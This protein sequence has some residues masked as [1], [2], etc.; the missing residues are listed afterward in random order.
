[1][2]D[3]RDIFES[4]K[5]FLMAPELFGGEG[6]AKANPV[7]VVLVANG[8]VERKAQLLEIGKDAAIISGPGLEVGQYEILL[9]NGSG[10]ASQS[11]SVSVLS[12]LKNE[13][14]VTFARAISLEVLNYL[15]APSARG[16]PASATPPQTPPPPVN[17][18]APP[19]APPAPVNAGAPLQAPPAPVNA[20]A[21][22]QAPPAPVNAGAPPQAP[23]PPVNAGAPPQAPPASAATEAQLGRGAQLAYTDI[24]EVRQEVRSIQSCRSQIFVSTMVAM[25][26]SVVAVG[27]SMLK[28]NTF[29]WLWVSIGALVAF[30]LLII[31]IT[32][33]LEKDRAINIRRGF[34]SAM[35]SL[36]RNG[37]V[38]LAYRGW[39]HMHQCLLAC[40]VLRQLP[41]AECPYPKGTQSC[42]DRGLNAANPLLRDKRPVPALLDSFTSASTHVYGGWFAAT[43]VIGFE[44]FIRWQE[45]TYPP[46]E[47]WALR[48]AVVAALAMAATRYL[49]V[50]LFQTPLSKLATPLKRFTSKPAIVTV[51]GILG[52]LASAGLFY[53]AQDA[54][55]SQNGFYRTL[56]GGAAVIACAF[57]VGLV[58]FLKNT[59]RAMPDERPLRRW[60]NICLISC[61]L[62]IGV[63]VTLLL[64]N[65]Q[66]VGKA[67]WKVMNTEGGLAG[68]VGVGLGWLGAYFWDNLR[69]LRKGKHATETYHYAWLQITRHCNP[70]PESLDKSGEPTPKVAQ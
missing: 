3:T 38:S 48:I 37:K 29:S 4:R 56:G 46:T 27:A 1:L 70:L 24:D 61:S 17:A 55:A 22:P 33:T 16:T 42:R 9:P 64:N 40:G 34:L 15:A 45:E 57:V 14:K 2:S 7:E 25:G 28:D 44:A 59:F 36:V 31:G 12:L 19:Q 69:E 52:A 23:P 20:G 66:Q 11:C 67:I 60:R 49:L 6:M 21:P 10:V 47:L 54:A 39:T 51:A 53:M 50:W 35:T 43:C 26:A 18:G 5:E 32:A 41:V 65:D 13:Y 62:I 63:A 68:L 8:G 30:I 58:M